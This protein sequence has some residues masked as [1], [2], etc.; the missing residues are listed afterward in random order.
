MDWA[1]A[2]VREIGLAELMRVE[3]V[4]YFATESEQE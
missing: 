4:S 1:D 2:G 3:S